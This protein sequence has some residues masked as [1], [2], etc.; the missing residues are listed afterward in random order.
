MDEMGK[1]WATTIKDSDI[2]EN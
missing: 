1:S 2:N